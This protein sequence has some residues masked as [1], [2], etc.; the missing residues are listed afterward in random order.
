MC[1]VLNFSGKPNFNGNSPCKGNWRRTNYCTAIAFRQPVSSLALQA[2]T[3][4]LVAN[5][6]PREWQFYFALQH[7]Y[8]FLK[9]Q[10]LKVIKLREFPLCTAIRFLLAVHLLQESLVWFQE[11][12]R[13][14]SWLYLLL[15]SSCCLPYTCLCCSSSLNTGNLFLSSLNRS[16]KQSYLHLLEAQARQKYCTTEK[17]D[18]WVKKALSRQTGRRGKDFFFFFCPSFK[19]KTGNTIVQSLFKK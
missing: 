10:Y 5:T 2:E 15:H 4:Q 9:S 16:E 11:Q 18:G 3:F 14:R 7:F 13:C 8:F 6:S 12:G 17:A 1:F 19:R